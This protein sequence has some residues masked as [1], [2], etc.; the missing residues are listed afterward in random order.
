LVEK[1]WTDILK[2][3]YKLLS[4]VL[5]TYSLTSF[6]LH[7]NFHGNSYDILINFFEIFQNVLKFFQNLSPFKFILDSFLTP[8]EF[9]SN[10]MIKMRH[11]A[12][13]YYTLL[14]TVESLIVHTVGIII[15]AHKIISSIISLNLSGT[16]FHPPCLVFSSLS[17][18]KVSKFNEE[19][20]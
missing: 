12:I 4:N 10:F 18:L 19:T 16:F 1:C 11:N 2:T 17:W 7:M 13:D 20:D 8:L 3:F 14:T 9:H 5:W 15:V 6:Q